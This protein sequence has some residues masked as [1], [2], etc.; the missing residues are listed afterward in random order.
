M[1]AGS[2]RAQALIVGGQGGDD[3]DGAVEHPGRA[4]VVVVADLGDLVADAEHPSADPSFWQSF[5]A[6]GELLLQQDV[7]RARAGGAAV[8]W[9]ED[10]DV[11]AR[12]KAEAFRDARARHVDGQCRDGFGV[13][14]LSVDMAREAPDS[15]AREPYA[16]GV[17]ASARW[18]ATD[19]GEDL[20]AV[21]T[22][23]GALLLARATRGTV[24][25]DRILDASR[26]ALSGSADYPA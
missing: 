8:H 9:G 17:E 11:V 4:L 18:M 7:E 19:G 23:V 3:P 10:L 5:P 24:L 1:P 14:G 25:S 12:V 2:R 21:S 13:V 22:L 16:D 15:P 6:W 26:E 20:V